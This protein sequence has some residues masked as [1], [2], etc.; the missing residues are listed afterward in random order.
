VI[1]DLNLPQVSGFEVIGALTRR[2]NPIGIMAT[3]GVYRETYLEVARYLGAHVAVP[4]PA[5]GSNFDGWLDAVR[6]VIKAEG[7]I[8]TASEALD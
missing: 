6:S 7:E 5:A 3:T 8:S 2:K 1:V 4:K